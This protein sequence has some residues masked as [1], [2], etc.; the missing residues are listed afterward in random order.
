M[1][2]SL[3]SEFHYKTTV[4]TNHSFIWLAG[5]GI[6][7]ASFFY[8]C[9][10]P[11]YLSVYSS[12]CHH[13]LAAFSFREGSTFPSCNFAS[14]IHHLSDPKKVGYNFGSRTTKDIKKKFHDYKL[15]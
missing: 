13:V 14:P 9:I 11:P 7:P 10:H 3:R 15:V 8:I 2:V 12:F 5:E 6:P 1:V 4:R